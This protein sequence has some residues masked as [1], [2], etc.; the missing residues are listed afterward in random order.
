MSITPKGLILMICN[1]AHP[2]LTLPS[3][4]SHL[5]AITDLFYI[6]ILLTCDGLQTCTIRNDAVT[7]IH[8]HISVYV[9]NY[10]LTIKGHK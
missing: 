5:Q 1:P 8:G 9:F 10:F 3:P 4:H 7:H 2:S 6:T